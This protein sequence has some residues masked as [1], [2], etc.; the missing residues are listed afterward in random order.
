MKLAEIQLVVSILAGRLASL[1]RADF[2]SPK[3]LVRR[4]GV[5]A[6][7]FLVVHFCGLRDYTSVLSGTGGPAGMSWRTAAF[8][9]VTY[10]VAWLGLVLLVPI[11]L[12]AAALLVICRNAVQRKKAGTG[13]PTKFDYESSTEAAAANPLSDRAVHY[14]TDP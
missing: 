2:L 7:I 11:L 12:I 6:G 3:D 9:G 4:A 8:F 14:R 5:I 10:I 13:N 1:W